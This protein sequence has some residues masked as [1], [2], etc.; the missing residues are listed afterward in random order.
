[1][2]L[3]FFYG[4]V[5]QTTLIIQHRLSVST[6]GYAFQM[7]WVAWISTLWVTIMR[8]IVI[9]SDAW[10]CVIY[11][12]GCVLGAAVGLFVNRRIKL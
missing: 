8:K 2:I 6:R 11:I 4:L 12:V 10:E 9:A 3:A 1:M 5:W 7:F